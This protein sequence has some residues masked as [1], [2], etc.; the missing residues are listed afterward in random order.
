MNNHNKTSIIPTTN[1]GK[2]MISFSP[3]KNNDGK[4]MIE[5][6]L[7]QSEKVTK[8]GIDC[9]FKIL[10]KLKESGVDINNP[11][12][13]TNYEKIGETVF[14]VNYHK[15]GMITVD[16]PD[17]FVQDCQNPIV[18]DSTN[19]IVQNSNPPITN[20]DIS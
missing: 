18:Q 6:S 2:T 1:S 5:M 3:I 15:N 11:S 17:K 16:Y 9:I 19:P 4:Y 7:E 10:E 12:I 8:S 20:S 13:L 14:P